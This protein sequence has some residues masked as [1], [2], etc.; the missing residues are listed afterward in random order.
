MAARRRRAR[1]R[2][3]PDARPPRRRLHLDARLLPPGLLRRRARRVPLPPLQ[4]RQPP[5]EAT[6]LAEVSRCFHCT[7]RDGGV[8]SRR[9]PPRS[10]PCAIVRQ[11]TMP[12]AAC[13]R[14]PRLS[15]PQPQARRQVDRVQGAGQDADRVQGEGQAGG[16]AEGRPHPPR[17]SRSR[18][19]GRTVRSST[20]RACAR[21]D[22]ARGGAR[23][24]G[25][26]AR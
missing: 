7:Q 11:H 9:E 23:G 18:G 14:R 21:R 5:R 1:E 17:P 6:L 15:A 26:R 22:G 20:R 13:A 10:V 3:P 8:R 16:E 4:G 25:G 24:R 2:A 19:R 12:P